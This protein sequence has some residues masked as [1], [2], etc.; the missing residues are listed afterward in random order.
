MSGFK[1]PDET[2]KAF[3]RALPSI[4]VPA[5]TAWAIEMAFAAGLQHFTERL[6]GEGAVDAG[7]LSLPALNGEWWDD[8]TPEERDNLRA[9]FRTQL[10]AAIAHVLEEGDD[11]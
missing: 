7:V 10:Q 4:S 3:L 11:R 1:V 2:R 6:V 9:E 5:E 8:L